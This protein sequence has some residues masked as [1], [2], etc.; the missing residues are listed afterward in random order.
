LNH[1]LQSATG[2]RVS[3]THIIAWA[4]VAALH[5][6]PALNA[7]FSRIEGVPHRTE[8]PHI[9]IGLAIDLERRDGSRSLVVPNVKNAG[10]LGFD[11][12]VEAY[13][14]L[15]RKARSGTLEPPDFQG[16][17]ITLTNPGTVGTVASI[18]RLMA[19]QGAI[20]ATGAI[21]YP[22]ENQ[23]MSDQALSAM[24]LSKV[25]TV[26][27]T[28]DHRVIQGAESGAFLARIHQLLLGNE[29]FYD[30][31]FTDLQV[32]YEPFRWSAD[33]SPAIA[34]AAHGLEQVEKEARV[35]QLIN[36]YRVRGHLIAHLDPLVHKPLHHPEL[37]PATYG[38][39]MWDFDREFV[40]GGLGGK[41]RATLREIL[42][43]LRE[44]YCGTTGVE[45][46]FIQDPAQKQWLQERL[47]RP[48][49]RIPADTDRQ[50]RILRKLIAAEGLEK[51]LHTKFIGHKRFSLEGA[52]TIMAILD[53]LL[54]D[55]A[56][57]GVEEVVIGMAHRGRLNVLVNTVGRS[58]ARLFSEFEGY[59]DPSTTQ[60]SG[61]VKYHLG[62]RGS[63]HAASGR[64]IAV[65]LAPNPS[66]L[67]AVNPV[68]EGIVRAGQER[69]GDARRERVIPVLIHG[70]A[71]F[72]GQG[73]VAETLNLSQLHGYRTGGTIHVIINN[74]IG[75]TTLPDDA[76]ST[77]YCTDVARMV[78]APIFHVNGDDPEACVRAAQLALAYRRQFAKDVV[79]D[80]FCFRRHG[81]NEG[82]E[83]SY[84]QPLLY[85]AIRQHPSVHEIYAGALLRRRAVT[86][87]ELEVLEQESRARYERAFEA[88]Q[89]RE[90]H[91]R[92]DIPLAV[93]PEELGAVRPSG[94]TAVSPA[95]LSEVA[96]GLTTLPEDFHLHPKLSRMLDERRLLLDG[97][98]SIDWAFAEALA[99]GTLVAEG[100]GVRLSGQDSG[101][102]TFSQR[103]LVLYD[104]Q[105]GGAH[106]PLKH[107][108]EAQAPFAVYD[109]LLS[110]AAVLGFEFGYSAADP[111]TLVLWEAQFG[112][113][114]NG[115]QV[116][117]DQFIAGSES[118]W[119]VPN[120]LVLLLPHGYEGQGPEHSSARLERFLQ[121]CA[122][123][124]MQVCNCSTP[125]QYFHLLRRQ[126]RDNRRKPLIVMTP[127]S[128]LR[129]PKAVSLPVELTAGK[130]REV[131]P[132]DAVAPGRARRLL[133]CSGKVYY[134]LVAERAKRASGEVAVVRVEQLYPFPGELLGA[135]LG[136]Y[137]ALREV[138]WVQEE[139]M[140]MGA[141]LFLEPR[142][143]NLGGGP[144]E[145]RFAGRQ[146]SASTATG[147]QKVHLEE[148][149]R[150]L[151]DA[152]A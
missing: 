52:E 35:L 24:G 38:L 17:S 74:Q 112:D 146:A 108:R 114:A 82:D 7:A 103:H 127:K 73:L 76:R 2:T 95:L 111:L 131:I 88:S 90:M 23:A 20:I 151:R 129:H 138:V 99:F 94:S 1:Y 6:H 68:V 86:P 25:M 142:L 110:E 96:R 36:A 71:A 31:L 148:Q 53:V 45:Y 107:I 27:C 147:S 137:T 134:D 83:P 89:R 28:Y 100:T 84:T 61:D 15:V 75:F 150:L 97:D 126:M 136:E 49:N 16:T 30:R 63:H 72:A 58:L 50:K 78:Q 132:D 70:D 4:V 46:M 39:T 116:I 91:F 135:L 102:G 80:M 104:A 152:F 69:R 117:I 105:G 57:A 14:G 5:D 118:K 13:D 115:A 141:W 11:R 101:R 40:T 59:V 77:P 106:T 33:N 18:P 8:H 139:P 22:P 51:F 121:L 12:F 149:A 124:N 65:T 81:H 125:A 122:E 10:A 64:D 113:F 41:P 144:R 26:T 44:A 9:N 109:S 55:A 21:Q 62:A 48:Q 93:S 19:G 34:G 54:D 42:D 79:V 43:T 123:D 130:F 32:P 37:D 98:A 67:E 119:Q 92:P 56:D 47:E 66:H 3:F 120:D 133:L 140:N 143:R 145:I 128:L 60:G 87:E 85:R 29:G